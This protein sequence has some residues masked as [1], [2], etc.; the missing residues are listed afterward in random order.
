MSIVCLATA[1]QP[2]CRNSLSRVFKLQSEAFLSERPEAEEAGCKTQRDKKGCRVSPRSLTYSGIWLNFTF[3]SAQ[4]HEP[5]LEDKSDKCEWVN[6]ICSFFVHPFIL[7]L[8]HSL[9]PPIIFFV[10][11]FTNHFCL[12]FIPQ[13]LS[14]G[15]CLFSHP[16][17]LFL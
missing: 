3:H 2:I 17:F 12:S 15:I 9:L 10:F 16:L 1:G 5:W 8:F 11:F 7:L 4:L 13:L 14:L 6:S